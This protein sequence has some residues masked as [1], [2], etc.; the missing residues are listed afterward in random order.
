VVEE[1][2]DEIEPLVAALGQRAMFGLADLAVPAILHRVQRLIA[3]LN[4]L[5]A[6]LAAE[7]AGRGLPAQLGY[8]S[9][10]TWLREH[11]RLAAG[12]A[13]QLDILGGVIA[14]HPA[15]GAAVAAGTISADQAV[16]IGAVISDLGGHVGAEVT[17]AATVCLLDCAG[18]LGPDQLAIAGQ[19]VLAH[20]APQIAE[21]ADA[22][23]LR[24]A[25]QKAHLDRGLNVIAD[26]A[27]QRIRITGWLTAEQGAVFTA[28]LAPYA[29]KRPRL[30]GVD[31]DDRSAAQRRADAL[32]DISRLALCSDKPS[33]TRA[34]TPH[35]TVTV[36]FDVLA[37]QLS[38]GT[39]DNGLAITPDTVRR[40][41]CDAKILPAVM[42]SAGQTL[43]LGR[44]QRTW[45][46]PA[47]RAVI[48]RDRG[49]VFPDCD[50]PPAWCDVHHIDYFSHGGR[51]DLCNAA[52]LCAFHHYLIHHSDWT[53][54]M[55]GDG[56]P[57][58]IPPSW[59]DPLRRPRRNTYW[60]RT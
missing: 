7:A 20:V 13:R 60:R 36:D 21:Q 27:R 54:T 28:A 1:M 30:D 12:S 53:I 47:R 18:R 8:R 4:A 22:E 48:L 55:T 42:G 23:A 16:T 6:S 41:A 3:V 59:L 46:G 32:E 11:L 38:A 34:D 57:Y 37:G 14:D 45:T 9:T 2:L 26:R 15:V 25:E 43:D 29:T 50:K 10:R 33:G 52:L 39:F 24:R 40:L 51:T 5:S 56:H 35:L 17:E 44:S 58:V 49:C 19:R 31:I